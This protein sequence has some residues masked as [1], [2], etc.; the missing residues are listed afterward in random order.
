MSQGWLW[1]FIDT[2]Q[3]SGVFELWLWFLTDCFSLLLLSNSA[4]LCIVAN[5]VFS[6]VECQS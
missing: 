5:V 2:K 4:D 3:A 1:L 6:V